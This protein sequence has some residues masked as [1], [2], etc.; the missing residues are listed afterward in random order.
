MRLRLFVVIAALCLSSTTISA[1][2]VTGTIN[3]S[4]TDRSGGAL[5]GATITIRNVDTGLERIVVADSKGFYNAPFLPVGRYRVTAELAGFG[6]M[7]RENVGVELNFTTVQDF[8]LDPSMTETVTV[9]ADAPR[10]DTTDGEI[11]Q[12]LRT[13]QIMNMPNPVPDATA[14]FLRLATVFAGYMENPTSGQDNPTA[15]SGSSINFNGAGTRGATFQI[16]GVNNDDSSENQH[17]QGVALAT[18][19]SFQVLTNNYSAEFGR[20][21]G[22]VV[23]VQTKS[24]TNDLSG[25]LY[26]AGTDAE[27]NELT[28]FDKRAGVA[29]PDSFRRNYGMTVGFPI[30]RDRLFMYGNYEYLQNQGKFLATRGVF[31]AEDL[32]LPRLTLGNDTPANRAWQDS[33]LARWPQGVTP[34]NPAVNSRAYTYPS[35]RTWPDRDASARLDW[36]MTSSNTLTSRYQRSHQIRANDEL[37][38]GETTGQDNRQS[39]IGL[40][41]T[42]ILSANTVQEAR[43]GI[44]LRSTNVNILAGNDTPIVRFNGLGLTFTILGNAGNFP[45]NRNQRDNQLVYNISSARFARHTLKAGA[46]IRRSD[47][48]DKADN[49]SRGFWQF[50]AGTRC[51]Q[52]F[53]TAIHAFMAGCASNYW[54]AYGPFDLKNRID[55]QN[56]YV[57]DD[58]RPTDNLVLNLGIR[59]ERVTAPRERDDLIDY[60]FND[61]TYVDPRLGFAYTPNW[62]NNRLLRALTGGNGQFSIRGGFGIFHGRVF[63][64]IFSQGGAN[65]RFNPPNAAFYALSGTFGNIMP[66]ASNSNISDPT[67]G[68]VFTP[69]Q[70]ARGASIIKID[71]DLQMPETRQWNLTFERQIF[72]QQRLR[73]SYIGTFGKNLLQY[74]PDNLPIPPGDPRS[75]YVVAADWRCAGTGQRINNVLIGVTTACP[76]AVPIGANEISLRVPRVA[77]RRPDPNYGGNTL[78]TNAAE[79]WYHAGQVEWE[80]GLVHGFN[81][82]FSYTFSK[83]LDSGSEATFVGAGDSNVLGNDKKYKRGLSRFDNRHRI[84]ALASYALPFFKDD[85]TNRLVK[86]VLGGWTISTVVRLASGTPFTIIDSGAVDFDFDGFTAGRPVVVDPNYRGG[87]VIDSPSTSQQ[88]MPR[89]AFR[90]AEYGDSVED[91]V[92]RNTFFTGPRRSVDLGVYKAIDLPFRNTLVI[93]LD[94]FNVFDTVTWGFPVNDIA[95]VNFGKLTSTNYTPR[96]L[97][98]GFRWLY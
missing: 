67:N 58:W 22:A 94:A 55:E 89:D 79:S 7:R 54:I 83:T 32:A 19:K 17:R 4:V 49:Y 42:N 28:Y 93:R 60:Q 65:V 76:T 95:S 91:L 33:I 26:G 1:Q 68:F 92:G 63:Q 48:N 46:D 69:G 9:S 25:E 81:G 30:M 11:K 12:T 84:T 98:I 21:Y 8:V 18:I 27:W 44:G 53:P 71:P 73:L 43:L 74:A 70:I 87:W 57:Q 3:G 5:P 51:G 86:G 31:T 36:N 2:T 82:R 14:G 52:N 40:T 41:W 64:S 38:I 61:S 37:I 50:S 66:G 10:I 20:G 6:N 16:N 96:I 56:V 35:G 85:S 47:L 23:L 90:R 78:I 59:G 15:S 24:G 80:T 34:N 39:N 72:T 97:Q 88:K 45:I 13:E 77:E 75:Q 29:K 62:E